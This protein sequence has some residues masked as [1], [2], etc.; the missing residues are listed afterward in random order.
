M[1]ASAGLHCLLP[2]ES[3]DALAGEMSTAVLDLINA[4]KTFDDVHS[5]EEEEEEGEEGEEEED[6]VEKTENMAANIVKVAIH[7]ELAR[8]LKM[9]VCGC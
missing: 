9:G 5:R 1:Y 2:Q 6:G 3:K 8:S 4:V 7:F